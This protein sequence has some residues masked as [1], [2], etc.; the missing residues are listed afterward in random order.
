[1]PFFSFSRGLIG[2]ISTAHV[3][4]AHV[5]HG[6]E[7]Q[8]VAINGRVLHADGGL[9]PRTWRH[10]CGC[11]A[12]SVSPF[13]GRGLPCHWPASIG[14]SLPSCLLRRQP[15][16]GHTPLSTS[17][18]P[19][20]RPLGSTSHC[21]PPPTAAHPPCGLGLAVDCCQVATMAQP[22]WFGTAACR[23]GHGY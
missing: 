18:L 9:V 6:L 3:L 7:F 5:V 4:G 17:I 14:A 19:L 10:S 20:C 11:L 22:P 15:P 23:H 1:M 12:A 16:L 21:Q 2:V 13:G 8:Q